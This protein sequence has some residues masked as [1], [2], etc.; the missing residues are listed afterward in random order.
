M[1]FLQILILFALPF[2]SA[3]QLESLKKPP[4]DDYYINYYPFVEGKQLVEIDYRA[5]WLHKESYREFHHPMGTTH[6]MQMGPHKANLLI[7]RDSTGK[8]LEV[9][10]HPS[11]DL[12]EFKILPLGHKKI[13]LMH[14]KLPFPFVIGWPYRFKPK[15]FMYYEIDSMA[16]KEVKHCA[17]P[18]DNSELA[19]CK[20]GL[21]DSTGKVIF[22]PKYDLAFPVGELVVVGLGKEY[23]LADLNGNLIHQL[24]YESIMPSYTFHGYFDIKKNG[25]YGLIDPSGKFVRRFKSDNPITSLE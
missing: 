21:I 10:N 8:I 1:K 23:G 25:K 14:H 9:Y 12:S 3:A 16:M 6:R 24:K 19:N 20:Q 5:A 13:E 17:Y 15:Y 11:K 2:A 18:Y 22:E 7:F 4:E